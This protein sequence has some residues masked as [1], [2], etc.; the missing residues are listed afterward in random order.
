MDLLVLL[1]LLALIYVGWML[2]KTYRSMEQQ[3]REINAKCIRSQDAS[4]PAQ[5]APAEPTALPN[6]YVQ[7]MMTTMQKMLLAAK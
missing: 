2:L 1:A 7:E 5:L 4:H 3:L 6:R